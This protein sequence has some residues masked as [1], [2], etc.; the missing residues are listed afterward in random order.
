MLKNI[1]SLFITVMLIVVLTA[2]ST[3]VRRLGSCD[4]AMELDEFGPADEF[5][6]ESFLETAY[7]VAK[8]KRF[9]IPTLSDKSYIVFGGEKFAQMPGHPFIMYVVLK[10]EQNKI[11]FSVFPYNMRT[12][13]KIKEKE[14]VEEFMDE[15]KEQYKDKMKA[16]K[17]ALEK[18][19]KK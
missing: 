18:Y 17:E 14:I 7:E 8:E 15:V 10:Q 1:I 19:N 2:C 16:Y 13:T 5:N 11:C 12:F 3:H 4:Y 6:I 9:P